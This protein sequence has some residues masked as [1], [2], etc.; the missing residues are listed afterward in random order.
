MVREA[1]NRPTEVSSKRPV[2]VFREVIPNLKKKAIDPR[3]DRSF[4]SF[5][6]DLYGKSYKFLGEIQEG[7]TEM[8][9]NSLSRERGETVRKQNLKRALDRVGS[10]KKEKDR[11][12]NQR[13]LIKEHRLMED[14]LVSEGK[15]PYYLKNSDYKK[16]DLANRYTKLKEDNA[17]KGFIE[18]RLKKKASKQRKFL[19]NFE[20]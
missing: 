20:K 9:K 12:E 18:K 15:N 5:N 13:S 19:P 8:L 10:L 2:S 4:G 11:K 17:Y 1:K 7:E 3:F 14:K 6:E 16:L